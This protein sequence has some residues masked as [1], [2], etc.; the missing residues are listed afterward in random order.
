MDLIGNSILP[1]VALA[2]SLVAITRSGQV[3]AEI[4]E[5]KEKLHNG[6]KLSQIVPL[7]ENNVQETE[8]SL[9]SVSNSGVKAKPTVQDDSEFV[10]W[11]KEDWLLKLGGLLV[12]MGVLFLLSV[13]F[14]SM[15]PQGKIMLGY[16]LGAGLMAF[17]FWF[18]KR[19]LIGGSV[20]H[21]V[22]AVSI[23]ITTYV[24]QTPAYNMF[25]S[26]IA[27]VLMFLTSVMVAVTAYIYSRPQMAHV[28]LV[29]ALAVPILVSGSL[30][31][32]ET[33]VYLFVVTLGVLWLAIVTEWRTLVLLSQ[34]AICLY[35]V[36][37]SRGVLEAGDIMMVILFGG[38]FFITSVFSIFRSQGK[39]A[40]VDGWIALL[41][42]L[43]AFAW[44]QL[45][46]PQEWQSI[47]LACVAAAYT[48]GFFAVYK[49]TNVITGFVIYGGVSLG[50][51]VT[52]VMLE[53]SGPAETIAITLM[54]AGATVLTH[55]LSKDEKVTQFIALA[56]VLP[57]Y[58]LLVSIS[59][60]QNATAYVP[61]SSSFG[62]NTG[63]GV[64]Q[65]FAVLGVAA[66]AYGLTAFY[67]ISRVRS[68]ANVAGL[69]SGILVVDIIWQSLHYLLSGSIATFISLLVYTIFGL[70]VLFQG[71]KADS[72][73]TIK[74]GRI[75][76]VI[77][78]LRVIL[79]DAWTLGS[80]TA[81]IVVCVVIGLLL[82]STSFITKKTPLV[83]N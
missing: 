61:H 13:T 26:F 4:K 34:I 19:N 65:E 11:L 54:I 49:L 12:L 17:G 14:S 5:L 69:T 62:V 83:A 43:Y 40:I 29:L 31:F 78:A 8:T 76:L 52:S 71:A 25:D 68:L 21:V 30:G 72:D 3:A 57:L 60:I 46:A 81:G 28:G 7:T 77:V 23:I 63:M 48:I 56:N 59:R 39:T 37:M 45:E 79:I 1:I 10:K 35:S 70:T 24:A 38:L 53:L 32:F 18:S 67:F 2:V 16:I 75:I 15:G 73:A 6:G 47:L 33:L 82:L 27:T 80:T 58:G 50:L 44:I 41:N 51:L 74:V 42:A 20:I 64:G 36:A 9:T 55:Y 66:I 22:G